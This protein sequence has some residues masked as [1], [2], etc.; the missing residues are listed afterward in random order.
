MCACKWKEMADQISLAIERVDK[1][2]SHH[3]FQLALVD[4]VLIISKDFVELILS[5]LHIELKLHIVN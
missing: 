5:T 4:F 3:H 1:F 2:P